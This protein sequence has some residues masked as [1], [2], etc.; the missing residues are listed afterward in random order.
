M[1]KFIQDRATQPQHQLTFKQWKNWHV[2]L[3]LLALSTHQGHT[4]NN[5]TAQVRGQS[6]QSASLPCSW[7]G[8]VSGV[9]A[10]CLK[11]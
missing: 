11:E 8:V 9:W 3:T 1:D 6:E 7:A 5:E 10:S 2:F 4:R